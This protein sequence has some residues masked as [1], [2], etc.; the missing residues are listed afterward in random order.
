[1]SRFEDID[2][3][4]LI[5]TCNCGWV[6]LGHANPVRT[7]RPH[8]GAI[9]LWEQIESEN[10]PRSEY[11]HGFLVTYSQDM[12]RW[13]LGASETGQYFVRYGLEAGAKRSIA[14][15]IF[16]ELSLRFEAMQG[17]FPF[18]VF[19]GPSSFSQ[20]DLVS[21]LIGFYKALYPKT[22]FLAMCRPVSKDASK[23]VW[24]MSGAVDAVKN[25]TFLPVFH[26]C[27]D[28][29]GTPKF[30][31]AMRKIAPAEKAARSAP[32][33]KGVAFR[34]WQFVRD[35]RTEFQLLVRSTARP[36]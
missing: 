34:D 13:G 31:E 32:P 7:K 10:G 1:M 14:L 20:E 23:K 17:R 25:E 4:R 11:D 27:A 3:G 16:Q 21:N 29:L 18:K 5:Y 36:F 12:R 35:Q 28:C 8:I 30:P 9:A 26:S 19:S 24:Q 2:G 33:P 6:D 22:D 15:A